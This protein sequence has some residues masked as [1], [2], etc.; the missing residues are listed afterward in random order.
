M[1]GS[2]GCAEGH[3]LMWWWR[4]VGVDGGGETMMTTIWRLRW[5]WLL[6]RSAG[7]AM[8]WPCLAGGLAVAQSWPAK[9]G[10][11]LAVA[12]PGCLWLVVAGHG[13]A[14][15]GRPLLLLCQRS[16]FGVAMVVVPE[17]L[18]GDCCGAEVVLQERHAS[19]VVVLRRRQGAGYHHDHE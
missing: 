13:M 3:A 7:A 14:I 18:E 12:G 6:Q 15:A 5:A 19:P 10:G 17:G 1:A 16:Q 9:A 2:G 8:V 4:G 11:G